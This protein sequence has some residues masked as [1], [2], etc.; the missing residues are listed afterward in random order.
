[1]DRAQVLLRTLSG[2]LPS[3]GGSDKVDSCVRRTYE[4][5]Q[6]LSKAGCTHVF[7]IESVSA[8]DKEQIYFQLHHLSLY[9]WFSYVISQNVNL[10]LKI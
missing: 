6:H 1:M 5:D 8:K 3:L 2:R 7:S 10:Q 4:G 9:L